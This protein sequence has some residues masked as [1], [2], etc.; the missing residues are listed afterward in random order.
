MYVPSH[1]PRKQ[2]RCKRKKNTNMTTK[3]V[4]GGHSAPLLTGTVKK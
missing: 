3:E 4:M 2:I 1:S